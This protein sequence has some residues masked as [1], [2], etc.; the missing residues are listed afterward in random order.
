MTTKVCSKCKVEK[1]VGEFSRGKGRKQGIQN[2][3]KVCSR[4]RNAAYRA[5]NPEKVKEL[6]AAW[7][8]ANLEKINKK[9]DAW[10]AANPE[11]VKKKNALRVATAPDSYIKC[12]LQ[13]P[14]PPQELIEMKREQLKMHR[15]T[16]ELQQILQDAQK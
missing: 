13:L 6:V 7:R 8:A 16:K 9:D 3:C 15:A 10:R 2:L 1:G 12:L 14:D 5:A 4:E 11:K